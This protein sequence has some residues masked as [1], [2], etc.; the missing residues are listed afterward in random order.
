[1]CTCTCVYVCGVGALKSIISQVVCIEVQRSHKYI[2]DWILQNTKGTSARA[3]NTHFTF[4]AHINNRTQL[5]KDWLHSQQ[6]P[7]WFRGSSH[8]HDK[9]MRTPDTLRFFST[10]REFCLS[11]V[12]AARGM[13]VLCGMHCCFYYAACVTWQSTRS[14]TFPKCCLFIYLQDTISC[15]II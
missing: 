1:M 12:T 3:R 14:L 9:L 2:W 11:I 8:K 15:Q 10:R 5:R 4:F 7:L 13:P 6:R